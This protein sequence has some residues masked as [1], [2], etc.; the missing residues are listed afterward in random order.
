MWDFSLGRLAEIFNIFVFW[1]GMFLCLMLVVWIVDKIVTIIRN[2]IK[3]NKS[4]SYISKKPT[5]PNIEKCNCNGTKS[6]EKCDYSYLL[7]PDYYGD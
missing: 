4:N 5:I 7:D 3:R 2:S 1:I 6:V